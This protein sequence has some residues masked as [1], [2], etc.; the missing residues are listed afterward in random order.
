M[1]KGA[2]SS[3]ETSVSWAGVREVGKPGKSNGKCSW[4]H[5]RVETR[6]RD[7]ASKSTCRTQCEGVIKVRKA[8]PQ[9][10]LDASLRS[11]GCF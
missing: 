8:K 1:F 2:H 4:R 10:S 7:L 5:Q 3:G 11:H 6:A 9:S